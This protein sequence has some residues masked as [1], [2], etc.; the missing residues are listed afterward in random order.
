MQMRSPKDP[1][2][3]LVRTEIMP[4]LV[5]HACPTTGGIWID[6]VQYWD[7]FRTQPGFPKPVASFESPVPIDIEDDHDGPMLSPRTGRMM[8]KCRAG[9]G[10]GFRI[11]FEPSSGFW[12]DKG[13]FE[14]LR[15]HNLHDELH[16]ICSPE[17]QLELVR[18]RS[19]QAEQ[20]RFEKRLGVE[21]C[22]RIRTFASWLVQLPDD[23][24]AMAYLMACIERERDAD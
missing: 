22:E 4:G 3:S 10:L 23:S 8:R 12:L 13:E 16:L 6:L 7:W 17:Y 19:G 15:N 1:T 24:V 11:D 18:L 9:S 2:R 5:G 14:S 21:H 20:S